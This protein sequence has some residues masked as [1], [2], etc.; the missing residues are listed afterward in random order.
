MKH[1]HGIQQG[2]LLLWVLMQNQ[3]V[4]RI[5]GSTSDTRFHRLQGRSGHTGD[6]HRATPTPLFPESLTEPCRIWWDHGTITK[7]FYLDGLRYLFVKQSQSM[8][9][10]GYITK[11][12]VCIF[13][14]FCTLQ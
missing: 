9:K 3:D 4:L 12:D 14:R 10:S 7:D 6:V 5:N 1:D 13:C 11:D 8:S 2:S